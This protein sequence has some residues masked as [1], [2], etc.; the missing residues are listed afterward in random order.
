MTKLTALIQP[1]VSV[2]TDP[3]KNRSADEA[4]G[5][6]MGELP[7]DESDDADYGVPRA[8]V[9][10]AGKALANRYCFAICGEEGYLTA[11]ITPI[12]HFK[13]EG[14]CSDQ[15]GPIDDLLPPR[16]V[17]ASESTWEFYDP[18]IKTPLD[19]AKALQQA[20]FFWNRDFQE[21]IDSS[22][23]KDL[24]SLEQPA[25]KKAAPAPGRRPSSPRQ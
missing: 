23:T 21:F 4:I 3:A 8:L 24:S 14:A 17:N 20:G 10:A 15:S 11:L 16:T 2:E 6:I 12:R 9:N 7:Q 19:A 5:I 13:L 22:L 1:G 18:A 25:A